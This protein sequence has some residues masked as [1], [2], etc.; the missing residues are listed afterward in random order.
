MEDDVVA[1]GAARVWPHGAQ[2]EVKAL[3]VGIPLDGDRAAF[4]GTVAQNHLTVVIQ[5]HL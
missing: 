5:P 3:A 4:G 2:S 1:I